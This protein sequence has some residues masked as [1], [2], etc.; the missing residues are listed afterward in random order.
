MRAEAA[1]AVVAVAVIPGG[2]TVSPARADEGGIEPRGAIAAPT[3]D[4]AF[5]FLGPR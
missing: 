1:A 3:V 2:K 5:I 4:L